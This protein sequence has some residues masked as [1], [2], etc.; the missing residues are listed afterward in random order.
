MKS[1]SKLLKLH[2][3]PPLFP[4]LFAFSAL[5]IISCPKG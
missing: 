4:I 2:N 3:K 1:N 5:S